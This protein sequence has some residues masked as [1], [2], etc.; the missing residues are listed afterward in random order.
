MIGVHPAGPT[1]GKRRKGGLSPYS[2][3]SVTEVADRAELDALLGEY[4]TV[5]VRK[6]TSAGMVND[7]TPSML[8]ASFWPNLRR[9]LPPDGRLMLVRDSAETLVG[10]AT[11]HGIGPAVGELKRLYVRPEASGNGLGR[12]LVTA[13]MAAARSMGWRRLM[14]NI[15]KDNRESIRIF[16]ALGFRY[17]SRYQECSDPIE[18]DPFFVYMQRDLG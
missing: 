7:Y 4:Y 10:C 9:V 13:Q 3:T 8:K 6:V 5:I 15:I 12:A 2:M 17:V 11:V 1:H 18:A 16:E 14:V